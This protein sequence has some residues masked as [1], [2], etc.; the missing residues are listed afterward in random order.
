MGGWVGEWVSEW[1][2]ERAS[3]SEFNGLFE[4]ANIRVQV[5]HITHVIIPHTWKDSLYIETGPKSLAIC[6]SNPL[7]WK[8]L[9][10][11]NK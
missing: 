11:K 6:V 10:I 9:C 2:S 7:H 8:L 3:E 1:V 5:V 4:T